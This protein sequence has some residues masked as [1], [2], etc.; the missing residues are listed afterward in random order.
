MVSW[1]FTLAPR[2][3][4][5]ESLTPSQ[6]AP[7]PTTRANSVPQHRVCFFG[8]GGN[9]DEEYEDELTVAKLQVGDG[10]QTAAA[11]RLWH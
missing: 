11:L 3:G 9:D 8:F 6:P 4:A 1:W 5:A 7:T 10:G 2:R